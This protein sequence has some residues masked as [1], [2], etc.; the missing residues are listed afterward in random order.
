MEKE[1]NKSGEKVGLVI[2]KWEIRYRKKG[3]LF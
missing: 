3:R 2:E 1:R